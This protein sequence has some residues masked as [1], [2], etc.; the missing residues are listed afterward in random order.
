M[1]GP[2][3]NKPKNRKQSEKTFERRMKPDLNFEENKDLELRFPSKGQMK[4]GINPDLH[5][6]ENKALEPGLPSKA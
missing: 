1:Y 6:G 4:R 5:C 3:N 2:I